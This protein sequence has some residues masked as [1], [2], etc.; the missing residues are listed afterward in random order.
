[1]S[2]GIESNLSFDLEAHDTDVPHDHTI[3]LRLFKAVATYL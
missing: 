2:K 3:L 1:M